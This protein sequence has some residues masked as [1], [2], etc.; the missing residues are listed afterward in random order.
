MFRAVVTATALVSYALAEE[1]LTI[2]GVEV[3]HEAY[4][5]LGHLNL[6]FRD[7]VYCVDGDFEDGR[8]RLQSGASLRRRLEE[9]SH[10]W[11]LGEANLPTLTDLMDRDEICSGYFNVCIERAADAYVELR[12]KEPQCAKLMNDGGPLEAD[13][14]LSM[15][16]EMAAMC[17]NVFDFHEGEFAY[18]SDVAENVLG[19]LG[20]DEEMSPSDFSCEDAAYYGCCVPTMAEMILTCGDDIEHPRLGSLSPLEHHKFDLDLKLFKETCPETNWQ[21]FC[22]VVE[23][24]CTDYEDVEVRTLKAAYRGEHDVT[25]SVR[26]GVPSSR[27]PEPKTPKATTK[28]K[29]VAPKATTKPKPVAPSTSAPEKKIPEVKTPEVKTPETVPSKEPATKDD[30]S[31]ACTLTAF[32]AVLAS[33]YQI[34]RY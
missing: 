24:V 13:F 10:D 1:T 22:G 19:H 12:K 23:D 11:Y 33:V 25:E 28:P 4:D 27:K 14:F 21:N 15:M 18:C 32:V 30:E 29:P 20:H 3:S 5:C 7:M 26:E 16:D 2:N 6:V 9:W 34:A 31:S 8:R 17:L